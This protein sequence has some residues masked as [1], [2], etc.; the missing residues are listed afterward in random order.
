MSG[1]TMEVQAL[2]VGPPFLSLV[3]WQRSIVKRS[4]PEFDVNSHSLEV[5]TA[6][7]EQN[8]VDFRPK[9]QISEAASI[10]IEIFPPSI[11]TRKTTL[12]P[13]HFP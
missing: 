7:A 9:K 5:H 8:M 11:T 12:V 10:L 13:F 1:A 6:M 4:W 3:Y 2:E